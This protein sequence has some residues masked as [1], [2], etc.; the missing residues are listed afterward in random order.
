MVTCWLRSIVYYSRW[1]NCIGSRPWKG[2][3]LTSLSVKSFNCRSKELQSFRDLF[4]LE[5]CWCLRIKICTW[6]RSHTIILFFIVVIIVFIIFRSRACLVCRFNTISSF[7]L[8]KLCAVSSSH[9]WVSHFST[10]TVHLGS[11]YRWLLVFINWDNIFIL[12]QIMSWSR[13]FKTWSSGSS[14]IS[15]S[16]RR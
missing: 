9:F 3:C 7:S 5:C 1:S 14:W 11:K 8:T 10:L 2:L 13:S 12:S 6:S 15:C 16:H 4:D